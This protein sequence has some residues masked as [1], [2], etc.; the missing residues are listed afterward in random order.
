MHISAREFGASYDPPAGLVTRR[1]FRRIQ[2]T[3]G[4]SPRPLRWDR[5][6]QLDFRWQTTHLTD[7]RGRLETFEHA[8]TLLGARFASG[9]VFEVTTRRSFERLDVPFRIFR[10]PA[11]HGSED[12]V[13]PAGD[14]TAWSWEVSGRTAGQ[15]AVTLSSAV[16]GGQFWSGTRLQGRVLLDV[17][18]RPGFELGTEYERNDV[19]LPQGVFVTNLVRISSGW[20]VSPRMSLTGHVQYDDVSR[21][22]GTFTRFRWIVRQGSDV[23]LVYTHNLLADPASLDRARSLSTIERKAASKITFTHRF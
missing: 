9:D 5:V 19:R 16:Q 14:H 23:Y 6:R 18:P 4:Y 22:V 1:A 13:I 8:W 3:V 12:V 10:R 21:V 17:R 2:P 7:L 20:H 11:G 15:R